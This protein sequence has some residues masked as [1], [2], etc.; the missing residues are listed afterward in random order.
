MAAF[1][2]RNAKQNTT[3]YRPLPSRL[4]RATFPKGEGFFSFKKLK[5]LLY[6]WANLW[7]Y[8]KAGV[9][10]DAIIMPAA[11]LTDPFT[12]RYLAAGNNL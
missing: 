11:Q 7:Y 10:P 6:N 4:R 5:I 1:L 12:D 3:A 9:K 8:K 2:R